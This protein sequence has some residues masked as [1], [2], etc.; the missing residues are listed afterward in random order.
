MKR[1]LLGMAF[2]AL[3]CRPEV[4][5]VEL[6]NGIIGGVVRNGWTKSPIK[7][8][9]VTLRTTGTEVWEALTYSEGSGAFAFTG[10]PAGDYT[11]CARLDGY[12]RTCFGGTE[13]TGKPAQFLSL[14]AGQRKQDV[15]LALLPEGSV[16]G[17]VMDGDGD[18][19]PNARVE[20]LRPTY[21]RRSLKWRLATQ[22]TTNEKGEYHLV[23]VQ[24]GEYRARATAQTMQAVRIHPEAVAGQPVEEEAYVPQYFPG[25]SSVETATS[26]TLN[27][28][29][30]LKGVDFTLSTNP[31]AVVGA[32]IHPPPGMEKEGFVNIQFLPET[33]SET[34]SDSQAWA[35]FGATAPEYAFQAK[36]STG[37]HRLIAYAEVNGHNYRSDQMV[38]VEP[39]NNIVINFVEGTALSGT[40]TIEGESLKQRGPYTVRLTPADDTPM[41]RQ[42]FSA[43]VKGNGT[44]EMQNVF[45][46]VWD[47]TVTPR[48]PGSYVK[49]MRL[50]E[51]DVLT[52]DMKLE[53]GVRKPLAIVISTKGA[54]VSGNVIGKDG[55]T[56]VRS[57][58]LLA[59]AGKNED[60]AS[61][62]KTTLSD[63]KGY[64][65]FQG[66][67]PG[68]YRVYAFD[69]M[70]LDEYGKPDFLKPFGAIAGDAFDVAEG[71]RISHDATL[72]VREGGAE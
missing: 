17:T 57:R 41:N 43:E 5:A 54:V 30:D 58:L 62:Y 35:G 70:K 37:R 12:E 23:F 1:V 10:V 46:G 11:L 44:F 47:V 2:G 38:D 56:G 52:K 34:Q 21:R 36:V 26:L 45:P 15:I 4:Q 55:G 19:I 24:P 51:Q 42:Q 61:F 64:F 9:I 59:P 33:Q 53:E 7:S 60:A 8:A 72:I 18:P 16:S 65:E 13:E 66:V 14:S 50:G 20:L 29:N 3:L 25:A 40:L 67:A 32:T 39:S 22:A 6:Q 71:A 68:S 69:R 48:P 27:A 28:G 49:S 63:A 31:L